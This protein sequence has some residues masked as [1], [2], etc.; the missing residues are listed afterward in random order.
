MF[1]CESDSKERL[2]R[3][4]LFNLKQSGRFMVRFERIYKLYHINMNQ[5]EKEHKMGINKNAS[6]FNIHSIH[7]FTH[8]PLF[9]ISSLVFSNTLPLEMEKKEEL[10]N[11][12]IDDLL[13]KRKNIREL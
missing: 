12:F 5:N 3:V 8:L 11:V 4:Q 2:I 7:T 13:K 6:P 1:E 10:I 9:F